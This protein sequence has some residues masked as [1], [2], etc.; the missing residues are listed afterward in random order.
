MRR[1]L[2]FPVLLFG[3]LVIDVKAQTPEHLPVVGVATFEDTPNPAS[4]GIASG[5]T[6]LFVT[7]LMK[8]GHY[9]LFERRDLDDLVAEIELGRSGLVARDS[10]VQKGHLQGIEYLVI[11]KITNFGTRQN[12]YGFIVGYHHRE[13]YVRVDFRV[14][15]AT[16]GEIVYSGAGEGSDSSNGIGFA[17]G[18]QGTAIAIVDQSPRFLRSQIGRATVKAIRQ[19][20]SSLDHADLANRTSGAQAL[21]ASAAT[22]SQRA[23]EARSRVPGKIL[24]AVGDQNIIVSLGSISGFKTGDQLQVF[25]VETVR[26]SKGASV[27]TQEIPVGVI[28][29]TDV[30]RDRS[31]AARVSGGRFEE[32]FVVRRM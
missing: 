9:K 1:I 17:D 25:R 12:T 2:V 16:T 24:A 10:R 7:E 8:G 5:L 32:G 15:D 19:A 6:E 23:E 22:A 30:Q 26:D 14:I 4:P 28:T 18:P 29:L 20:A 13:S 27:F 21:A 31:K 3:C 11:G